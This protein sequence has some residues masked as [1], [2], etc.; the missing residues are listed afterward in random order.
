MDWKGSL[1]SEEATQSVGSKYD[2]KERKAKEVDV[3]SV[4]WVETRV[5]CLV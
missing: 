5:S 2:C 3:F 1:Q 4:I